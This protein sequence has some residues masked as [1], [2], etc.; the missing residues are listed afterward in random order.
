MPPTE[1]RPRVEAPEARPATGGRKWRWE[2]GLLLPVAVGIGLSLFLVGMPF[3]GWAAAA[4][5]AEP[6]TRLADA[7]RPGDSIAGS[8]MSFPDLEGFE[9]IIAT[10]IGQVAVFVVAWVAAVV[11]VR[12]VARLAL[13][14]AVLAPGTYVVAEAYA[15]AAC[16]RVRGHCEEWRPAE[17]FQIE[18]PDRPGA[19]SI[20]ADVTLNI[21]AP[22][23]LHHTELLDARVTSSDAASA[24]GA[25]VRVGPGGGFTF[26][27]RRAAPHQA[28]QA[29][30]ELEDS[31]GY[32]VT[33]ADGSLEAVAKVTV[34]GAG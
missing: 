26:D 16:E 13:A 12:A 6:A 14:V 17:P 9:L 25:I 31:F 5:V 15:D 4:L 18:D 34:V 22:G 24:N 21:A 3:V 7:L 23:L 27:P 11:P 10:A 30:E 32:V 1:A 8:N 20:P 33:H 28:L 29:G 19:W 2:T